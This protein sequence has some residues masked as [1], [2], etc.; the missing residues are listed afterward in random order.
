MTKWAAAKAR[1]QFS[2][3]LNLVAYGKERC[4]ITR[5]SKDLLALVP[6][7]DLR[8]LELL[9]EKV[10][11]EDGIKALEEAKKTGTT[12]WKKLK[13]GLKL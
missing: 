10:D 13:A 7:E 4:V 9:E 3:I 1:E 12:S 5:Q 8:V 11:L 6:I 2:E